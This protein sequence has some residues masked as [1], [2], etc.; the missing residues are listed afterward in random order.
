MQ[1]NCMFVFYSCC[2]IYHFDECNLNFSHLHCVY[3]LW[4]HIACLL[5]SCQTWVILSF[6]HSLIAVYVLIICTSN[7]EWVRT[8]SDFLDKHRQISQ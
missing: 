5:G 7:L 8:G 2:F 6:V 1:L 3:P 4:L